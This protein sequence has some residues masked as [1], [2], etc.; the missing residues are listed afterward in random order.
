MIWRTLEAQKN[1]IK[2]ARANRKCSVIVV[3]KVLSDDIIIDIF[4]QNLFVLAV[5]SELPPLRVNHQ[6]TVFVVIVALF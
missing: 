5:E 6:I 2:S 1:F 4:N 3:V